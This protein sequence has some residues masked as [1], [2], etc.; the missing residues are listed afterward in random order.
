MLYIYLNAAHIA[1]GDIAWMRFDENGDLR[2]INPEF[3][4]FG[5][6]LSLSLTLSLLV[7]S[8][9]VLIFLHVLFC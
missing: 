3:G 2:A 5:P 4:F 8:L 9:S 1:G 6:S 7:L